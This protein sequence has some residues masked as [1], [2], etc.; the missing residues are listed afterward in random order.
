MY[1]KMGFY[2]VLH[3]ID[4][5]TRHRYATV[6]RGVLSCLGLG[7]LVRFPPLP[8]HIHIPRNSV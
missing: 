8:Y 2:D 1:V 4:R 3:H 5:L 7:N 6:V